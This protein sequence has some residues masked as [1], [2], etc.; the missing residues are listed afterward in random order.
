MNQLRLPGP[1][2]GGLTASPFISAMG[3]RPASLHT[4][5]F[6]GSGSEYFRIWIVNLLL[7]LV[8][9]GLYY[10]WA[11]TR[12][13]HYF[14]GNTIVIGHPLGFHGNPRQML[15]GF[16]LVSLLMV[17]YGVAGRVSPA[18]GSVAGLILAVLWPALLRSSLQFRLSQ[19][20]WRGLRFHFTGSLKG[21]YMA[22]LSPALIGIGV[23]VLSGVLLA[24][25]PRDTSKVLMPIV[26]TGVLLLCGLALAPYVIWRIK[27]YQHAHY[28]L[29]Q[30]QTSF[31]ATYGNV[32]AI[33]LKTGLLT[34]AA[35]TGLVLVGGLL[36]SVL[37]GGH[38][39][40][41]P[42]PKQL[43][44]A[45][46]MM[47]PVL[48]GYI[49]LTQVIVAPYFSVHLQNLVWTQTGNRMVRFKSHLH[50]SDMAGLALKNWLLIM[51]TLGLYWPFAAVALARA[52]LQAIVIHT[53]QDPDM[54]VGQ[55]RQ[56][57]TNATGDLAAD[58]VGIDVGL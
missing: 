46:S 25:L 2:A 29:G 26:L 57:S 28:A 40:T 14:Y 47:L 42:D 54:L 33:F 15:R 56:A 50:W 31:K 43:L 10:P 21:A 52:R 6:T 12:K 24:F 41:R 58:L 35:A 37:G 13:L 20:S 51:L 53:R 45:V 11:K 8:T 22:V 16:L 44:S 1:T 49:L 18:A 7:T 5:R 38:M 30:L 36:G 23:M 27:R 39:S 32:L 34:L 9:L 48:A 3:P 4:I 55:A 19:T 17:L